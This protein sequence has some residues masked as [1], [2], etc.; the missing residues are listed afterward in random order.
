M[1]SCTFKTEGVTYRW[2]FLFLPKKIDGERRWLKFVT[3]EARTVYVTASNGV[4]TK[5]IVEKWVD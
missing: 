2:G 3:I 4:L 5:T 1:H